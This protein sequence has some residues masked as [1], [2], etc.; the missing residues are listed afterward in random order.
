LTLVVEKRLGN[1][2]FFSRAMVDRLATIRV[3]R[4]YWRTPAWLARL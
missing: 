4:D 3:F 2:T 1:V